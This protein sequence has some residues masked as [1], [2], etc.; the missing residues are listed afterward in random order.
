VIANIGGTLPPGEITVVVSVGGVQQSQSI[1]GGLESDET[2][3]FVIEAP[4]TGTGTV[5]VLINGATAASAP[6]EIASGA[7]TETATAT[8]TATETESPSTPETT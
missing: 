4:G 8:E 3:T 5:S 2:A 7:P 6:V 1:A